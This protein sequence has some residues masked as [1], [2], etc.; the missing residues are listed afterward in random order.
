MW[1]PEMKAAVDRYKVD[2]AFTAPLD[3]PEPLVNEGPL[4]PPEY[5]CQYFDEAKTSLDVLRQESARFFEKLTSRLDDADAEIEK[6]RSVND[7]LREWGIAWK[8]RAKRA[9]LFSAQTGVKNEE[10]VAE[11][12]FLKTEVERLKAG[13]ESLGQRLNEI[14]V[15]VPEDAPL[16]HQASQNAP[17]LV[18]EK[19]IRGHW[20]VVPADHEV[21][22]PFV[23]QLTDA[24]G[25][26]DY[27]IELEDRVKSLRETNASLRDAGGAQ[28]SRI[29][30]LEAVVE[31][32]KTLLQSRLTAIGELEAKNTT[33]VYERNLARADRQ[34]L[35]NRVAELTAEISSLKM[36]ST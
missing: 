25:V 1:T 19:P 33:L 13:N 27:I 21:D 9:D 17:P 31:E 6:A 10:L 7:R 18:N 29:R 12:S 34:N 11:N 35:A 30:H 32:S 15:P 14:S 20:I 16:P 2:G 5:S 28:Q 26:T 22:P 3:V 4:V 24:M 8:E 36:S 23:R